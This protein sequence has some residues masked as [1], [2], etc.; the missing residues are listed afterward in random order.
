MKRA[1]VLIMTA[2][3]ASFCLGCNSTDGEV[4]IQTLIAERDSAIT[5][6]DAA[7]TERDTAISER[8]AALAEVEELKKQIAA[9]K[10]SETS[11][12]DA[13]DVPHVVPDNIKEYLAI[14]TIY[15][16]DAYINADYYHNDV[17][18]TNNSQ[19][20]VE[21]ELTVKFL[22]ADDSVVGVSNIST[23]ALGPGETHC[24]S[25]SNELPF[26]HAEVI[27]T[28]AKEDDRYVGGMSDVE[29]VD[30]AVNGKKVIVELTNNGKYAVEFAK[31]YVVF[32]DNDK[33]VDVDYTYVTDDDSELKAGAT[34]ID[35][36]TT[37]KEFTEYRVFY[38]GR[39]DS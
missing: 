14:E 2:V 36:I 26:D 38:Y 25:A 5:E 19:V 16:H 29:C 7:I 37:R 39:I 32:Y 13:E 10:S 11:V 30:Y 34:L 6:R 33:V 8:D 28:N 3:L 12:A 27:I 18:L 22:D 24:I 31:A 9:S 4:A 23:E 20:I 1:L 21:A 35:E 15:W 17:L